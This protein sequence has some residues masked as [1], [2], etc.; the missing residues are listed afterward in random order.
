MHVMETSTILIPLQV[1]LVLR[2]NLEVP[3]R[4]LEGLMK[5][6]R[7]ILRFIVGVQFIV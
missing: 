3:V 1:R 5:I 2:F 7:F 6:L 4:T